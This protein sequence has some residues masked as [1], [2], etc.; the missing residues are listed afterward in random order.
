MWS[1]WVVKCSFIED[2]L[3]LSVVFTILHKKNEYSKLIKMIICYQMRVLNQCYK[4]IGVLLHNDTTINQ[5]H[6]YGFNN[7]FYVWRSN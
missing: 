7:L 5:L 4:I 1:F 2:V 6:I 3:G